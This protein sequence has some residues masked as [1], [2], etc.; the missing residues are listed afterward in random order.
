[1][2]ILASIGAQSTNENVLLSFGVSASDIESTPALTTSALPSGANF[3]DN[4]NGTGSFTWTPTYLQ[5]GI[6]PVTFTAT[7]DSASVDTEIVD[8]YS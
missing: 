5:S 4:G 8:Y 6:Y 3:T 7:D 1:L 2:P